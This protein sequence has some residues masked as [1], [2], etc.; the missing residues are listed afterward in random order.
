MMAFCWTHGMG[1]AYKDLSERRALAHRELRMV[2]A[3][4]ECAM[5]QADYEDQCRYIGIDPDTGRPTAQ[6]AAI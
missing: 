5:A 3:L 4:N 2:D 1:D 6:R